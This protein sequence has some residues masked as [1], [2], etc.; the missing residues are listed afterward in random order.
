MRYA[1]RPECSDSSAAAVGHLVV[2][3][4][5][6][7]FADGEEDRS[8]GSECVGASSM[9]AAHPP[10]L[11]VF[12]AVVFTATDG[13]VALVGSAALVPLGVVIDLRPGGRQ[14][15]AGRLASAMHDHRR[16]P[17]QPGEQ[18]LLGAVVDDH[19]T[20]IHDDPADV[21]GQQCPHDDARM[22][23]RT[24][25]RLASPSQERLGAPGQL[26]GQVG[27]QRSLV[28]DAAVVV[29]LRRTLGFRTPSPCLA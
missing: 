29:E 4:V 24:V 19:A 20:G 23:R 11:S 13:S 9:I 7:A 22:D 2:G 26:V 10:S 1:A 17:R 14:R 5:G 15:A 25:L 6:W 18:P 28:G 12:H 21:A 8:V 3:E 16:L 27:E